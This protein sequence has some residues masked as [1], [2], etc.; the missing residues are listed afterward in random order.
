MQQ[1]REMLSSCEP[2]EHSKQKLEEGLSV[3]EC[4][5]A[6]K[7]AVP[8]QLHAQRRQPA[9]TQCSAHACMHARMLLTS[10]SRKT[11][12]TSSDSALRM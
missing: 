4:A 9:S 10:A 8:A 11:S 5:C 7:H 6:G 1:E 12:S 2:K 3:P